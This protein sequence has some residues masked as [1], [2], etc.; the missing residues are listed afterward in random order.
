MG[1]DEAVQAARTCAEDLLALHHHAV[2]LCV[3]AAPACAPCHLQQLVVWQ[4]LNAIVSAAGEAADDC[5]AR[6]HVDAS[7]QGACT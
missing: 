1:K 7:G 2:P 4:Q 5:R 3:V 6:R